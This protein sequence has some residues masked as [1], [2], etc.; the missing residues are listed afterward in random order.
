M[1]KT[2]KENTQIT[3]IRNE[4]ENIITNLIEIRSIIEEYYEQLYANK[5]DNLDKVEIPRNAETPKNDS[6][7]NRKSEQIDHTD[8]QS[9]QKIRKWLTSILQ[10]LLNSQLLQNFSPFIH[11]MTKF[12]VI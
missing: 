6:R 11:K 9:L 1:K 3:K 7:R 4:S 5:S 2:K 10:L 8:F 12:R